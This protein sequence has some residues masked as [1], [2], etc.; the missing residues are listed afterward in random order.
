MVAE[1]AGGLLSDFAPVDQST[2]T[3][4]SHQKWLLRKVGGAFELVS[5]NSNLLLEVL[6]IP[7]YPGIDNSTINGVTL[8]Q[9]SATSTTNQRFIFQ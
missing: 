9:H 2:W 5:I 6:G 3:N 8:D 4:A 1:T 7:L